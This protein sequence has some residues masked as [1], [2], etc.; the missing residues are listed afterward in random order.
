MHGQMLLLMNA[1]DFNLPQLPD[2]DL[3][4]LETEWNRVRSSIP[5]V[6]KLANDGREF[7]VGEDF[8]ARNLEAKYPVVLVPG[9]I[10]TVS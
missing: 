8:K 10:S 9:I 3:S 1:Y 5:E 6:W 7:Q 2:I 4:R